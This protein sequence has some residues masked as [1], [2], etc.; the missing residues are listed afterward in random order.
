MTTINIPKNLLKEKE[1]IVVP[2]R[3]YEKLTA[4]L[5]FLDKEQIWF[6]T[7]E[8]QKK[9][10]QAERDIKNK[11]IYGPFKTVKEL[12]DVLKNN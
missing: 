4:L 11:K 5:K 8:W 3:E 1:L 6:W 10:K 9:E 2:K 12:V 7:K